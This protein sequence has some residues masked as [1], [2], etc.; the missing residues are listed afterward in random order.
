V[1]EADP[2]IWDPAIG[3]MGPVAPW[4]RPTLPALNQRIVRAAISD[5][6]TWEQPLGSNRGPDI[7][8][9]LRWAGVPEAL[10]TAGKGYWCAAWACKCW[11]RAGAKVIRTASC[12]EI[13]LWA[14]NTGRFSQNVAEEGAMVLYYNAATKNK[15]DAVH[16]GIV[17]RVGE[18]IGSVEGNTTVEGARLERNGTTVAAKLVRVNEPN[19]LNNDPLMGF[20]HL[21]PLA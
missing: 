1:I 21:N 10:I 12:D 7:D 4:L 14:R 6:F 17:C 11:Y 20:V 16:V 18:Q 9:L 5:L 19:P 3:V 8:P 13:A 15:L 2:G